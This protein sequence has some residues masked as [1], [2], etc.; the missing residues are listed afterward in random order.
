MDWHVPLVAAATL[1]AAFMV[2]RFRPVLSAGEGSARGDDALRALPELREVHARIDSATNEEARA[3][4]L[5]DAGDLCAARVGRRQAAQ[6]FYLRA[7][8][9]SPTSVAIVDRAA[10]GFTRR[11]RALE[12]LLWRRLGTEAWGSD[13]GPA[14]RRTLEL[15]THLYDGPLRNPTRAR[16]LQHAMALLPG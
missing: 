9:A 4:A 6:G 1:F 15:L 11:P 14:T 7:M 12:A 5:C 16:A 3:A 13:R 10:T 8:R 2:W